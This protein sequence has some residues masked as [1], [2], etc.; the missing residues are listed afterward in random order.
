MRKIQANNPV[1]MD[2][3]RTFLESFQKSTE[4][5]C[6]FLPAAAESSDCSR[7][8][9]C[10]VLSGLTKQSAGCLSFHYHS[11]RQAERFGGRYIYFCPH[12]LAHFASPVLLG[13]R[14]QGYLVGGPVLIM[15]PEEIVAGIS[16]ENRLTAADEAALL[17]AL[18]AFPR[19]DPAVLTQ[20]SH[21]LF[22]I[23]AHLG[24]STKELLSAA[25]A[26][27]NQNFIGST[28]QD[29]HSRPDAAFPT[30]KENSLIYAITNPSPSS[31]K[32]A[33]NELLGYVLF[34]S[35]GDF[36]VIK[37][38]CAELLFT[39]SNAARAGGA[40]RNALLQENARRFKRLERAGSFEES[41]SHLHDTLQAYM[42][43]VQKETPG[44]KGDAITRAKQYLK[45]HFSENLTLADV[46][47]H[48]SLSPVY[49]SRL[50]K[51]STGM[52]FNSYLNQ[53]RVRSSAYLLLNSQASILDISSQSG[54]ED[55]SYFTKVFKKFTGVSPNAFRKKQISLNTELER[56]AFLPLP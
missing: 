53:L 25:E 47:S 51:E 28:L 30:D 52:T 8:N 43:L 33:L 32:Q 37:S 2:L 4:V 17:A 48:V 10:K 21:L 16:L 27:S 54:F 55:Q 20:L 7:C 23:A 31:A 29:L 15:D 22:I 56:E 34:Y 14:A 40:E 49:F 6:F 19:R 1:N 26:V 38:M 50:F 41:A 18:S 9:F 3:V 24:N 46:A 42:A 39:I 44:Q 35:A 5:G 13:G 45:N 11:A 12:G 36:E